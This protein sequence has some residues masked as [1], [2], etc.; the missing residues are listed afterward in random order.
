MVSKIIP[1][2]IVMSIDGVVASRSISTN[3]PSKKMWSLQHIDVIERI[4]QA[5]SNVKSTSLVKP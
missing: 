4:W 3:K 2:G 1:H 5:I